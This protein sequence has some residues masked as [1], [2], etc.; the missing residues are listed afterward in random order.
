MKKV[1]IMKILE[2]Q[3]K[4]QYYVKEDKEDLLVIEW[5]E[6]YN[7]DLLWDIEEDWEEYSKT[8]QFDSCEI[9]QFEDFEFVLIPYYED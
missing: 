7:E 5:T 6:Q 1:E 8:T 4:G 3:F 9:Y 2:E